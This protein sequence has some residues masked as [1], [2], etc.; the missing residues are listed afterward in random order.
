[1]IM[2]VFSLIGVLF[3]MK[4]CNQSTARR[5]NSK[6][7]YV[8]CDF[9]IRFLRIGFLSVLSFRDLTALLSVISC[10][11]YLLCGPLS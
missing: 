9:N 4:K 10:I 6:C 5:K 3:Y 1:M 2:M 8:D 11:F 7:A